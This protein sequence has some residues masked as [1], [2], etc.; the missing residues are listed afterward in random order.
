MQ[1]NDFS[2]LQFL[3]DSIKRI[4]PNS[5]AVALA[6]ILIVGFLLIT[7][8][9]D[10]LMPVFIAI[11]L[12]YLL[13]GMVK[14]LEHKLKRLPAVLIVFS[15]FMGAFSYLLFGLMPMLYKQLKQL[16][17]HTP[18]IIK[19]SQA[20]I[21][22]LPEAYPQIIS[23]DK[24]R[25]L[26]FAIQQEALSYGQDLLSF[27]A[28]S[29]VGI[30]SVL[31]YLILVPVLIFFCLKDK[32]ILLDWFAKFLPRDR[33]LSVNVWVEVDMQLGNYI[34][35]KF[36]EVLILGIVSYMT[37]SALGLNYAVLLS[38]FMGLQVII[39]YVGATLVTFPVLGVAFF[40]WGFGGD[41]F[42]YT[43][44]AYSIIQ[45]IDGVVLVPLLFSEA[46]NLHPAAIIVA[47][48]FFGGLWGFW[49]VFFAIPLATLVKAVVSAWPRLDDKMNTYEM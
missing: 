15:G 11:V 25:E 31:V 10:V 45:A 26:M 35:G 2:N 22:K 18:D 17:Q 3:K 7:S 5:Q 33:L 1:R 48:L 37:F 13:E 21:L 44:I 42:M 27:S 16:L 19:S 36:V 6:I 40:Q 49:G 9:A 47:I 43:V 29:V 24:L 28:S 14:K 20:E 12:A 4:L 8:L 46:V 32:K 39:P 34:R 38:V 23:A 30:I 41:E